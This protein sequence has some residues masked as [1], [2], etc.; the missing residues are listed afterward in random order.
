MVFIKRDALMGKRT[1]HVHIAPRG[2]PVWKGL[3]FRDYLRAQP[4]VAARYAGLK[5]GLAARYREDRERYTNAK[6]TFVKDVL[7]E[8]ER[9]LYSE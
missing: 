2:H 7:A 5:R 4:Q 1:H 9:H 3:I 8:A 6:S